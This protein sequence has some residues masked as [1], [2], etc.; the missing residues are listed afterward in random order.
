VALLNN[1]VIFLFVSAAFPQ[2]FIDVALL[3]NSVI[4][5]FVSAAFPQVFIDVALL[6]NPVIF[7]FASAAFP[8]VFI[9]VALLN[10]PGLL[11]QSQEAGGADPRVTALL[12]HG[13]D[14]FCYMRQNGPDHFCYMRQTPP[15]HSRSAVSSLVETGHLSAS[16]RHLEESS[17]RG[18]YLRGELLWT[19]RVLRRLGW[20]VVHVPYWEWPSRNVGSEGQR[21]GGLHIPAARPEV[22]QL[23]RVKFLLHSLSGL[24]L[25]Q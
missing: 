6:N 20:R 2:V 11:A 22:L 21:K 13:P 8:Q 5:L 9:D 10:N 16:S 3:N 15:S 23:A 1:S 24:D 17:Q 12:C 14:H 25:K 7:I 4:F 19:E 18:L